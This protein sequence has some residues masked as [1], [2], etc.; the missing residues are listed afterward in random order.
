MAG[1][2]TGLWPSL[3]GAARCL[4]A[5]CGCAVL[6]ATPAGAPWRILHQGAPAA[7]VDD[8]ELVCVVFDGGRRAL[9]AD[10]HVRPSRRVHLADFDQGTVR[11]LEL[12]ADRPLV[13][14]RLLHAGRDAVALFREAGDPDRSRAFLVSGD[15]AVRV[16]P[17]RRSVACVLGGPPSPS[18]DDVAT[19][20][21]QGELRDLTELVQDTFSWDALAGAARATGSSRVVHFYNQRH[22]IT[23]NLPGLI[24]QLRRE[25]TATVRDEAALRDDPRW[26]GAQVRTVRAA[27]QPPSLGRILQVRV[28]PPGGAEQTHDVGGPGAFF[29]RVV[30]RGDRLYLVGNHIRWLAVG[31]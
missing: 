22:F 29:Y 15:G 18:S 31:P 17:V 14:Q 7:V 24:D 6:A 27:A 28:T 4:L 5:G 30:P 13:L 8:S 21:E 9:L 20:V 26:R 16:L 10:Q 11:S 12:P 25:R 2:A 19:L 23:T 3:A 1:P